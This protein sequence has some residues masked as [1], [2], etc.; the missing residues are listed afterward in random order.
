MKLLKLTLD[1]HDATTSG[2][3]VFVRPEY[4]VSMREWHYKTAYTEIAMVNGDKF[5]VTE[6]AKQ[7]EKMLPASA[8]GKW[9]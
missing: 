2:K 8:K 3:E 1:V 9:L 6:T 4:I 7:I 5:H